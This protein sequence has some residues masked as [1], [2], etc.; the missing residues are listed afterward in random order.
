MPGTYKPPGDSRLSG[1]P[2][3]SNTLHSTHPAWFPL[4]QGVGCL[5][6][7]WKL[8]FRALYCLAPPEL[9]LSLGN[10]FSNFGCVKK[11]PVWGAQGP[12]Y[13]STWVGR[14]RE[15]RLFTTLIVNSNMGLWSFHREIFLTLPKDKSVLTFTLKSPLIFP[16]ANSFPGS[17]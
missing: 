17:G 8:A 15:R 14:P 13:L 7:V 16:K 4:L 3:G 10:L 6:D 5:Q 2:L 1:S 9:S 11:S 12:K